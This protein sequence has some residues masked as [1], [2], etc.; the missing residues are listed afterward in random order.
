MTE[1]SLIMSRDASHP[2]PEAEVILWK[3][4]RR[5]AAEG[6]RL[7]RQ[8]PIGPDVAD[9]ACLP[10]K[11][12]VEVD[13]ATHGSDAQ[14]A[15]DDRRRRFMARYGRREIRVAN[16]IWREVRELRAAVSPSTTASR[17]SSS[18]AEAGEDEMR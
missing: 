12:I 4:L 9:F 10:L 8:H 11:L 14:V 13:G 17:R 3:Y 16:F 6:F 1:R 2:P 15:Y 7:R 5:D 18:P